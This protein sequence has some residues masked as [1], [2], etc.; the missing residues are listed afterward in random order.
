MNTLVTLAV[1]LIVAV[2]AV[3]A[4]PEP[5]TMTPW[6]MRPKSCTHF[7]PSDALVEDDGHL[8][9]IVYA[10]GSVKMLP[11]CHM[12]HRTL[13]DVGAPPSGWAAY[14]HWQA[15]SPITEYNG[16]WPVPPIPKDVGTQTLFLFTGM[17]NSFAAVGADTVSI[18]Q[19]V[20]QYGTSEAGGG[21]YWSLASWY[22]TSTGQAT[23]STLI[24]TTSGHTV[25]GN[26]SLASQ[27]WTIT[28]T[29]SETSKDTSLNINVHAQE[30][31]AFVTLEV[32]SVSTCLE[33]P[34]GTDTFS[35]LSIMAGG[36]AVSASWATTATPGC[37]EAV[38]V[39]GSDS[40]QIKF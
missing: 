10:D 6:G 31:Y 29:D 33:F 32:Y 21:T 12:P 40:V 37:Q 11:Q 34:T 24:K 15:S 4:A 3:H 36:K 30:M 39:I 14:A 8:A 25:V 17:Q 18:I 35:E 28:A 22:V 2:V 9:K 38:K 20:L 19:P 1:L 23:Y 16:V 26:M 7:V 5:M 13:K 27:K